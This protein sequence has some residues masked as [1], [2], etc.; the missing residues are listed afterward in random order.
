[1][2]IAYMNP[3]SSEVSPSEGGMAN[4]CEKIYQEG[5]AGLKRPHGTKKERKRGACFGRA[6]GKNRT[7]Q[8]EDDAAMM[9]AIVKS[10]NTPVVQESMGLL[11]MQSIA[12]SL[13]KQ[14]E[15]QTVVA[16]TQAEA[17]VFLYDRNDCRNEV[18]N[19]MQKCY[20]PMH[21]LYLYNLRQYK[22]LQLLPPIIRTG[23]SRLAPGLSVG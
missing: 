21:K 22:P 6:R 3:A 19:L 2:F 1:V 5:I 4:S 14:A 20:V 8:R 12:E 15:A 13:N 17:I 23:S 18:S 9:S 11:A 16:R 10:S 7:E